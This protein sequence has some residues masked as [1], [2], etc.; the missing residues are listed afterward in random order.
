MKFNSSDIYNQLEKGKKYRIKVY[1]FRIPFL[2]WYKN[3]IEV[4]TND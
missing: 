4:K 1:G 3:I 2:S